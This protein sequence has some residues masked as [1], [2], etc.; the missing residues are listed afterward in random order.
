MSACLAPLVRLIYDATT[1][2][3]AWK[4]CETEENY[5]LRHLAS[6]TRAEVV[7]QCLPAAPT[8]STAKALLVTGTD[9]STTQRPREPCCWTK[10][11]VF[12]KPESLPNHSKPLLYAH[13]LFCTACSWACHALVLSLY[14]SLA[15]LRVDQL[16]NVPAEVGLFF[17]SGS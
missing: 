9:R 2:S 5:Q 17:S 14:F 4:L 15:L 3:K 16:K 11:V 12:H 1:R 6:N 10:T 7:R 13:Q 8:P